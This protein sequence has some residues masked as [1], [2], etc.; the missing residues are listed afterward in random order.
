MKKA[1]DGKYKV[2][3]NLTL[4][5]VSKSVVLDVDAPATEVKDPMGM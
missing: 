4:H 1:G 3:G 5:G 2:T